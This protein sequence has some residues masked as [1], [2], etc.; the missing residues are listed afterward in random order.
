M[1]ITNQ[2][3]LV[4]WTQQK[5]HSNLSGKGRKINLLQTAPVFLASAVAKVKQYP[6]PPAAKQGIQEVIKDLEQRGITFRTNSAQ[7]S[8]VFQVIKADESWHLAA[9]YQGLMLMQNHPLQQAQILQ[10]SLL[11]CRQL[12]TKGWQLGIEQTCF[13][14]PQFRRKI[15][16]NLHSFGKEHNRPSLD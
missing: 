12:H 15:N 16:P 9:D 8:P 10:T 13:L 11:L 2:G 1:A 5:P 6:V 14:W 3:C 4:L 7:N